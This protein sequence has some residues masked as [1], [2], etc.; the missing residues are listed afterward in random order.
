MPRSREA[1][2]R[3]GKDT[4]AR[5]LDC[6]RRVIVEEGFDA[7]SMR[8]LARRCAMQL[9][10]LQYYFATRDALAVEVIVRE[11]ALDILSMQAVVGTNSAPAQVLSDVVV[12]L[13]ARWRGE[14]GMVFAT[15]TYLGLHKRV[16]IELRRRIYA[17]FHGALDGVVTALDRSASR[18]VVAVRVTLITALVDGAAQQLP[19]GATGEMVKAIARQALM[20]ARGDL[21]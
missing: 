13:I 1:R 18:E 11:A 19:A 4:R 3:K 10:N 9:G 16:F 17:D 8:D 2:T 20:I 5:I 7:L 15:L 12:T 14:A 21:W 6:A